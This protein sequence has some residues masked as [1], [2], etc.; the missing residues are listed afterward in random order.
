MTKNPAVVQ[1]MW[2]QR[3]F[4]LGG[5]LLKYQYWVF[6]TL[7]HVIVKVGN[8]T[9]TSSSCLTSSPDLWILPLLIMNLPANQFSID[10]EFNKNYLMVVWSSKT[11]MVCVVCRGV[12]WCWTPKDKTFCLHE[13]Y[14]FYLTVVT[15]ELSS[16]F[17]FASNIWIVG[18][19]YL[20]SKMLKR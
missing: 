7:S 4:W 16:A 13:T 19:W 20:K 12:W 3:P 5:F 11:F 14:F 15:G 2:S 8:H 6:W 10:W 1:V 17:Q 9:C 18:I